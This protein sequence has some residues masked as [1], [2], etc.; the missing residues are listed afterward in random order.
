[1]AVALDLAE[2]RRRCRHPYKMSEYGATLYRASGK[3]IMRETTVLE[4]LYPLMNADLS[5]VL[6]SANERS[7]PEFSV[8]EP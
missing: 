1:M 8:P 5:L 3:K 4:H 7:L 6:I 2:L